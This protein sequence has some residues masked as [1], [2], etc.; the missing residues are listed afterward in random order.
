MMQAN[1]GDMMLVLPSDQPIYAMGEFDRVTMA[2]GTE[3]FSIHLRRGQNDVLPLRFEPISITG[4]S[5]IANGDIVSGSPPAGF[6]GGALTWSSGA[7]PEGSVYV[8][9]GRRYPEYFCY[10]TLP[11]DRPQHQGAAL[12]RRI[13]L[14]RFDLLGA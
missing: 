13:V 1:L 8:L 10:L 9:T 11:H 14:R 2:N 6:A 7:P 3:P 5:W 12:P 4:V